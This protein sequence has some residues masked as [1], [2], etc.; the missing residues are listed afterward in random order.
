M[1]YLPEGGMIFFSGVGANR[2]HSAA[3]TMLEKGATALVSWGFAGGLSPGFST[4]SLILPERIIA[5]DQSVY[6]VDPVWHE[7]LCSRLEKHVELHRGILAE[8]TTVL[9]D[10]ADKI[11][12]F[13]RTGA[14]AVDMESAS[15][16]LAAKEAGVPFIVIRAIMDGAEM[17]IPRSALNSIDK[18]GRVRPLRLLS[19]LVRRPAELMAL[20]RL[21]QNFEAARTTLITVVRQAGSNMFCP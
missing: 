6:H 12:L 21:G 3:R 16:A 1:I 17:P 9:A 13:Q 2:A 15:I 8:S 4:G 20:L 10:C 18:F 14:I 11:A 5:S 19:C 7:R